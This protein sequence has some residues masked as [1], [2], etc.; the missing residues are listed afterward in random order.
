MTTPRRRPVSGSL[1]PQCLYTTE[2]VFAA[3]GIGARQLK[4]AVQDG[5]LIALR[6]GGRLYYWGHA[7]QAWIGATSHEQG[8]SHARP[9]P[10]T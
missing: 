5:L 2:G 8:G 6:H 1:D 3:T 9:L 4:R 7:L 10:Q